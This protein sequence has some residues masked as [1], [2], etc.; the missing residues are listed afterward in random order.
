[1][2]TVASRPRG[3]FVLGQSIWVVIMVVLLIVVA[4]AVLYIRQGSG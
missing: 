3:R 2:A 4:A 1:M